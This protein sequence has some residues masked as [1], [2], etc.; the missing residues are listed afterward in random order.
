MR[1]N[2]PLLRLTPEQAGKLLH[3][4]DRLQAKHIQLQAERVALE[5]ALSSLHGHEAL[6]ALRNIARNQAKAALLKEEIAL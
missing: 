2:Y 6:V 3:D 4:F 1:R 5:Q